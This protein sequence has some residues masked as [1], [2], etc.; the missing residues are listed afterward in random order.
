[1]ESGRRFLF[2]SFHFYGTLFLLSEVSV[3]SLFD[4]L[5][6]CI[7]AIGVVSKARQLWIAFEV[8]LAKHILV[9]FYFFLTGMIW[10]CVTFVI[11]YNS[12]MGNVLIMCSFFFFFFPW[13]IRKFTCFIVATSL[14]SLCCLDKAL[15]LCLLKHF[16]LCC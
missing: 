11:N 5:G 16:F 15:H 8:E 14:I 1:M 13:I 3:A 10:F 2:E 6:F 7:F 12:F 9:P 4:T